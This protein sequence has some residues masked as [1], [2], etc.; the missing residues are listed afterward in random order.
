MCAV[1]VSGSGL[2]VK[3]LARPCLRL[4]WKLRRLSW[5][6]TTADRSLFVPSFAYVAAFVSSD[7]SLR[8]PLWWVPH[9]AVSCKVPRLRRCAAFSACTW[10]VARVKVT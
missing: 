2:R 9:C 7:A 1:R 10:S 4:S 8:R 6:V 5:S 3:V